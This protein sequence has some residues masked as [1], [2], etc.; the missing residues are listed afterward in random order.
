LAKALFLVLVLLLG[1]GRAGAEG[2]GLAG[3]PERHGFAAETVGLL[4]TEL[5]T[6]AVVAADGADRPLIPASTIKLV[7][8]IGALEVLG[9]D[10]RLETALLVDGPVEAGVLAGD[11]AIEGGGDV[12]LDLDDLMRLAWR[13]RRA[14]VDRVD[15]RF[16][17]DDSALPRFAHIHPEQPL[18]APYNAGL[19][20]LGLAFNRVEVL[21]DDNGRRWTLPPL[22]ETDPAWALS[23]ADPAPGTALPVK[24]P[25]LHAG[26]VFRRLAGAL[27]IALPLPERGEA[28]G[29][30]IARVRSKPVAGLVQ[31]MLLYSNNQL[32]ETLGL[33][34]AQRLDPDVATLADSAAVLMD[35][36][37][38]AI[39]EVDW[40]GFDVANHSGLDPQARATPRQLLGLVRHG[41]E[42]H[43]LAAL[44]PAAGWS[45]SLARRLK[46]PETAL[47]VWAKTGSLDYATTL[48]GLVLPEGGRPLVVA[49]MIGDPERR[50]AYDSV[51]PPTPEMRAEAAAW[52]ARARALRDAILTRLATGGS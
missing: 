39:D 49:L 6:G 13:L 18:D 10:H 45:G 2:I 22:D 28:R 51:K 40:T 8:A 20:G 17:I 24:D 31:D 35:H 38:A 33:L 7:T 11:V 47:R 29:E 12:E 42:H 30:L 26:H 27:G 41:L 32:A 43:E 16:I 4:V 5:D 19:G 44:M 23:P 48:A 50:R 46:T 37:T 52:E 1:P 25:G 3:L 21:N 9:A 14:G 36:V 15:G 34:A